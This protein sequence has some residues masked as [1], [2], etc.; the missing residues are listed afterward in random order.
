MI[1]SLLP[2]RLVN[3]ASFAYQ[4]DEK[5]QISVKMRRLKDEIIVEV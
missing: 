3:A 2:T 1:L 5:G 4:P